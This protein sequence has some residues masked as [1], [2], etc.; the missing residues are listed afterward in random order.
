MHKKEI[1]VDTA[2]IELKTEQDCKEVC[3]I[4]YS[5]LHFKVQIKTAW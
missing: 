4:Q 3:S 2:N 5:S 1:L